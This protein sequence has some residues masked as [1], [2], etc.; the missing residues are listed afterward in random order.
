MLFADYAKAFDP[1]DHNVV[2]LMLK[3]YGVP[4][5][6]VCWMMSFLC[7]RQQRVKVSETCSDWATL[8]GGMPQGFWLGPLIFIIPID[9]LRLQLLTH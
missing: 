1:V 3:S 4:D 8:R 9:D 5:F 2:L 7:D 6:I